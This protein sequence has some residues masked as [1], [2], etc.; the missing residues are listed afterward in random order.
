MAKK[1]A[2]AQQD[3]LGFDNVEQTLTKTES[4]EG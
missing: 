1:N 2:P 4:S 3:N